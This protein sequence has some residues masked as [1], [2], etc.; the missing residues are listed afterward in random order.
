MT[1]ERTKKA[2]EYKTKGNTA[3][4]GKDFARAVVLYTQAIKVT[5]KADSVFY[6]NRAACVLFYP[7][8]ALEVANDDNHRLY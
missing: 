6:P 8:P 4:A 7:I 1:Q 2:S 5:P 3:Y